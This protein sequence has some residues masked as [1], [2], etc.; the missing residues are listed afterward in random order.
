MHVGVPELPF[1]RRWVLWNGFIS[2]TSIFS[3]V[4]TS[5]ICDGKATKPGESE[6]P[7]ICALLGK[8]RPNLKNHVSK[9]HQRQFV[10]VPLS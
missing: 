7:E 3:Y 6:F 9:G 5:Q 10:L 1:G 4:F 8:A 2:R